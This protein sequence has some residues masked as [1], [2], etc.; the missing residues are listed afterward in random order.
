[1]TQELEFVSS[2][3]NLTLDESE[4]VAKDLS[5]VHTGIGDARVDV[6]QNDAIIPYV[7]RQD[8]VNYRI[9]GSTEWTGYVVG[10]SGNDR[11]GQWTLRLDGIGKR[12]EET[13][14]EYETLGN[15]VVFTNTRLDAAIRDYWG[16]TPFDATV[17]DQVPELVAEDEE[18]QSADTT[19][20]WENIYTPEA[21]E[22][23]GISNGSLN[24]LQS[25]FVQEGEDG[26]GDLNTE[27]DGSYSDGS[28]A[29]LFALGGSTL[30]WTIT[31]QYD[32]DASNVG[33]AFRDES[34]GSNNDVEWFFDGE[35]LD[36][37]TG[38]NKPL[39]WTDVSDGG[40][41]SSGFDGYTGQ[42]LEAGNSYTLEIQTP[43]GNSGD[44]HVDVICV[45]DR[46]FN[47]FFDNDNGGSSGY[48]DGP[49]LYP[50][51]VET[52]L[53]TTGTAFNITSA[54]VTSTW[55]DTSGTQA[56]A[57]S[58]DNG[59][60][61]VES[62]NTATDTFNFTTAGREAITRFT[63]GRYGS[64]TTATPQTGYLGQQV[65]NYTLDV[66]LNDLVVISRLELSRDHFSNLKT[67][68][69]YGDFRWVIEHASGDVDT[70]TVRS[71][72]RGAET[73]PTPTAFTEVEN[74]SPE[75]AAENYFNSVYLEGALQDDGTRPTAEVK[76]DD[77]I[78][79]DREEIT[80]GV[81]RDQNI[82]TE[83]GAQFRANALL[84]TALANDELRGTIS[85]YPTYVNPGYSYSVDFGSGTDEKTL[86]SVSITESA[87]SVSATYEFVTRTRLGETISTL[88]REGRDLG[89]QV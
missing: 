1:M 38:A 49:E 64:R 19:T 75:V 27:A 65:D 87:G 59:A 71:F 81:L 18:L 80:P 3:G 28:A 68:H 41:Y 83:A 10:F 61:F 45:Y 14:P 29:E 79:A 15:A 67:L 70:L 89:N 54:T 32:I 44:Y 84:Q 57:V 39:G 82:S 86:E 58:N 7:Q 40:F 43:S 63:L 34:V 35:Q 56:I 77:A 33:I 55:T 76:D 24:L 85:T 36:A 23:I 26:S 20:E 22:P 50:G 21:T 62:T 88:K 69:D 73:R 2:A 48:L 30:Q 60:N 51:S 5:K 47:Y 13:R 52:V 9:D 17:T 74:K 78:A 42:T 6:P 72:P 66:D 53:D 11:T 31:P 16:R 12:L 25:A 46:R 4:I 37:V 8:R